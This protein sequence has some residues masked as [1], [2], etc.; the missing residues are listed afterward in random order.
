MEKQEINHPYIKVGRISMTVAKNAGIRCA[1]IYISKNQIT[2]IWNKHS[3]ELE[4]IGFSSVDFVSSICKNFN[5]IRIGSGTSLLLVIYNEKLPYVA[6]ID[7][8]YSLKKEFWEIKTAEPRRVS[9]VD[10]RPLIW[11]AAKHTSNGNRNRS[12]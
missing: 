10:K 3:K 12:N 7:I 4:A 6:A 1:D 8:N 11:E 9:K 2:H 5:Q